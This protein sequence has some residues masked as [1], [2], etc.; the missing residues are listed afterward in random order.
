MSLNLIFII[1]I[2][3]GLIGIGIIILR[4]IPV[5]ADLSENEIMIL[6]RKKGFWQ[7]IREFDYKQYWLNWLISLEKF[8]RRVKIWFLKIENIL[9][10]LIS[11]LRRRS[12]IAT[13][14][15]REWIKQRELKRRKSF[16]QDDG[17]EKTETKQEFFVKIKKEGDQVQPKQKQKSSG[18]K[19]TPSDFLAAKIAEQ[20]ELLDDEDE[21]LPISE[22]KK[23]IKEEQKWIDLIV[24]N[25]K[26]ITAYKYLGFLYWRQHNYKDAKSS[27]EMA[28]KLGSKDKKVK[29]IIER[30]KETEKN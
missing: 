7:R 27:L 11:F 14:K 15:S 17:K 13:Q 9:T 16:E 20:E 6:R 19:Q 3:A 23:P 18:K 8:L 28:V 30:I 22:L 12:Q 24:E 1:A 29:E 4:K 21:D 25:P 26:N 2:I 5:L 10:N